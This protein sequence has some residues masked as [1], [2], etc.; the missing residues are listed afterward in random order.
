MATKFQTRLLFTLRNQIRRTNAIKLKWTSNWTSD[1]WL[2]TSVICSDWLMLASANVGKGIWQCQVSK[3]KK[4]YTLEETSYRPLKHPSNG[5]LS[6]ERQV[7]YLLAH[8]MLV[9][10]A[11][12][13]KLTEFL[14]DPL[15]SRPVIF[16]VQKKKFLYVTCRYVYLLI[17]QHTGQTG[18]SRYLFITVKKN[19]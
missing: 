3:A 1:C 5:R 11:T 7:L 16:N 18:C 9:I 4:W 17:K 19:S 6:S 15:C 2:V 10:I 14:T 13:F 12:T 8:F